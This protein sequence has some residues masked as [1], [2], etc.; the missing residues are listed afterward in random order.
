MRQYNVL[1]GKMSTTRKEQHGK[2]LRRS[3]EKTALDGEAWLSDHPHKVVVPQKLEY[4][5]FQSSNF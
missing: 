3:C 5:F 4:G 2:K 1:L